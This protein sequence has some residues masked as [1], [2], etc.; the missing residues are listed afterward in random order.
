MNVGT[1]STRKHFDET[2]SFCCRGFS[3]K[4]GVSKNCQEQHYETKNENQLKTKWFFRKEQ[5]LRLYMERA[6]WLGMI[7]VVKERP[8]LTEANYKGRAQEH[9]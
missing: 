4:S 7:R 5:L 8:E 6:P 2:Q 9:T 1:A 3:N